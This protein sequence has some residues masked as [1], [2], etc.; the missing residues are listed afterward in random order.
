MCGIW[1]LHSKRLSHNKCY[2]VTNVKIL[3]ILFIYSRSF[4][5]LQDDALGGWKLSEIYR[6]EDDIPSGSGADFCNDSANNEEL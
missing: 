1:Q 3:Y 4:Y 5:L 6:I 2:P